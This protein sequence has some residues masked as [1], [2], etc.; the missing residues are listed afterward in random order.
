MVVV[1]FSASDEGPML[2]PSAL[3]DLARLGVTNVALVRDGSTAGLVLEGWAFAVDAAAQA[4]CAVA[5]ACDDVRTLRPLAQ[6]AVSA[7]AK[8]G[9]AR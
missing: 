9:E 8:G 7:A 3:E 5:G 1:L 6:M 2:R 4:A